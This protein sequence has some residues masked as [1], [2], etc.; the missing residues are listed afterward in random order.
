M[1]HKKTNK[2]NTMSFYSVGT[3]TRAE[4]I[5]EDWTDRIDEVDDNA[6][7]CVQRWVFAPP[8]P[9]TYKRQAPEQGTG[10]VAKILSLI[11]QTFLGMFR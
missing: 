7:P 4:Q 5:G 6:S 1:N 3:Y 8:S 10:T 2:G 11:R 9:Y